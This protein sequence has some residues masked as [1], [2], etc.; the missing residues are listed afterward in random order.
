MRTGLLRKTPDHGLAGGPLQKTPEKKNTLS[1]AGGCH[2]RLYSVND[3]EPRRV[4][5]KGSADGKIVP[6]TL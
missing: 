3:E 6:V 5:E 1:G 4:L 2:I